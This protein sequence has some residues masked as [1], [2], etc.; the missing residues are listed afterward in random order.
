MT[1]LR[2]NVRRW[3]KPDGSQVTEA[4]MRVDALLAGRLQAV[5]P[6]YGWLSE[7]TPDGEA[8]LAEERLWI[9]DPI[10]GTRAFIEQR[11]RMV[12]GGGAGGQRAAGGRRRLPAH[13]GGEFFRPSRAKARILNGDAAQRDRRSRR[14]RARGWPAT[15]RR[16][17]SSLRR[18]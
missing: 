14:W 4:D 16:S 1:L 8:R 9:V 10:D 17:A 18:V 7:E 13:A 15:A 3:S 12:R 2:Q 6:G 11:Q 5:R